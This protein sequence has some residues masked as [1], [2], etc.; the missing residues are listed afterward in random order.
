LS[1][2][3]K[4]REDWGWDPSHELDD[5]ARDLEARMMM[6][7][8]PVSMMPWRRPMKAPRIDINDHGDHY[9]VYIEVPGV[10]KDAVQVH[11]TKTSLEVSAE[12]EEEKVEGKKT[13][14][15]ERNHE[16]IYR[17]LTFPEE[18]NPDEAEA[19][20]SN[21]L[22]TVKVPKMHKAEKKRKIEVK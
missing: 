11:M 3:V 5:M 20:A 2:E 6:P 4:K 10:Q 21:G 16:E 22:L 14:V 9:E 13:I 18:V 12:L 15:R 8:F 1:K 19:I 17:H 7:W